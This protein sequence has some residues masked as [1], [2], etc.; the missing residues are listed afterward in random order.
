MAAL[1][2]MSGGVAADAR[3]TASDVPA[4][5]TCPKGHPGLTDGDALLATGHLMEFLGGN[6][7]EMCAPLTGHRVP[8]TASSVPPAA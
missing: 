3:I 5:E 6:L 4:A 8:S 1:L 7:L 2:E